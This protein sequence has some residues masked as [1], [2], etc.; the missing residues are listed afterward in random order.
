M[1]YQ[2]PNWPYDLSAQQQDEEE[3]AL[4]AEINETCRRINETMAPRIMALI[5]KALYE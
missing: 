2:T 4:V 1:I 3:H 5:G